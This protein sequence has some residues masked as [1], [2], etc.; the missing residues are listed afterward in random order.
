MKMLP[1][2]AGLL[3]AAT[4][5]SAQDAMLPP[6]VAAGKALY[7]VNVPGGYG[8][9]PCHGDKAQ[10]GRDGPKIIGQDVVNIREQLPIN[11]SMSFIELEDEQFEQVA[12]YL[13]WLAAN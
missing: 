12:A 7:E 2:F 3:L 4:Q 5:A 11:D 13:Q 8:C 1:V 9:L 10:G 6:D